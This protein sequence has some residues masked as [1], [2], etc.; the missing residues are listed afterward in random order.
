MDDNLHSDIKNICAEFVNAFQ[1]NL[2]WKWEDRFGVALAEFNVANQDDI[3]GIL[4]GFLTNT[5]DNSTISNAPDIIQQLVN[6]F[7][8]LKSGQ[9]LFTSDTEQ[10]DFLFGIW[11]PWGNGNTISIRVAPSFIKLSEADYQELIKQFREWFNI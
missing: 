7:N 3:R 2:S 11:W 4:E 8:G 5:W 6:K 1:E 9:L 10:D